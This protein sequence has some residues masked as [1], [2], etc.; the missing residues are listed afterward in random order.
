MNSSIQMKYIQ[1]TFSIERQKPDRR[2]RRRRRTSAERNEKKFSRNTQ[3][4]RKAEFL[5]SCQNVNAWYAVRAFFSRSWLMYGIIL[6]YGVC[7][8]EWNRDRV[9]LCTNASISWHIVTTDT[10]FLLSRFFGACFC[11]F[12]FNILCD[13]A[14]KIHY[15]KLKLENGGEKP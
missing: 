13:E 9:N 11:F 10:F 6:S 14:L 4:E 15:A 5:S 1:P 12:S 3:V 7:E 8:C 2:R